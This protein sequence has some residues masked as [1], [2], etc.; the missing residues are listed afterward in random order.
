MATYKQYPGKQVIGLS[1]SL[2]IEEMVR[3]NIFLSGVKKIIAATNAPDESSFVGQLK[4][5]AKSYWTEFPQEASDL[6]MKMY[7]LGRIE[8]PRTQGKPV[9]SIS[10]GKWVDSE[11]DIKVW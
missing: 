1:L 8:Q 4:T 5:Y 10:N 9:H 6:A 3:K 2:C 11:S 7:S